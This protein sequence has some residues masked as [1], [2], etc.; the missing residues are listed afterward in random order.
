MTEKD[1]LDQ[2]VLPLVHA[3]EV[4]LPRKT[5][6]GSIGCMSAFFLALALIGLA[7][8]HFYSMSNYSTQLNVDGTY[9]FSGK[10]AAV[11]KVLFTD[12]YKLVIDTNANEKL[13]LPPVPSPVENDI[14]V[15]PNLTAGLCVD[16]DLTVKQGFLRDLS[17]KLGDRQFHFDTDAGWVTALPTKP[18]MLPGVTITPSEENLLTPPPEPEQTEN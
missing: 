11:Q 1:P 16:G 6:P 7:L 10:V 9:H 15:M 4:E 8:A 13:T 18:A 3:P 14:L 2:N 17:L 12:R 5:I